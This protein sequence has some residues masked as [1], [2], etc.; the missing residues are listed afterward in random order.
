MEVLGITI[1]YWHWW[2]LGGVF[3]LLEAF[4]SGRWVG[5]E[6]GEPMVRKPA[7]AGGL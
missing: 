3:L 7:A 4:V 1:D 6:P 2:I 5:V